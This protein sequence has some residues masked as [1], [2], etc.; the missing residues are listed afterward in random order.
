MF[1][2][3]LHQLSVCLRFTPFALCH[4]AAS[5]AITMPAI[6]WTKCQWEEQ[7]EL[8]SSLVGQY[9]VREPATQCKHWLEWMDD[10]AASGAID[11]W[12]PNVVVWSQRCR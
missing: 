7:P 1:A 11:E 4:P 5:G 6:S 2:Y 10:Y 8:V 9:S 12:K 3:A